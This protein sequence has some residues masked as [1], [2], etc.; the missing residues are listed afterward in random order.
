M[1]NQSIIENLNNA[2]REIR[3]KYDDLT[4]VL[5][6]ISAM[7]DRALSANFDER[8]RWDGND[9]NITIFSGGS[10]KWKALATSTK[11]KYKNLGWE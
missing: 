9:S 10:Q 3:K 2:F 4:P 6:I 8:G 5:K 1:I 11:D 7:I